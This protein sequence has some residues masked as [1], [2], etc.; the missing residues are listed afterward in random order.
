MGTL[1]EEPVLVGLPGDGVGD[2][3]PGVAVAAGPHVVA[4]LRL[5]TGVGDA[6]FRG[7]D[8][9]GSLVSEEGKCASNKC[10]N[11]P[12]SKGWELCSNIALKNLKCSS[13]E[14]LFNIR[15]ITSL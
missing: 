8:A 9:V 2:A 12:A 4:R 11:R 13:L 1:G 3:F 14:F 15:T 6:V 5:V 10:V 7:L